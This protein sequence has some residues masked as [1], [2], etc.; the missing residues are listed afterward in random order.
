MSDKEES[1]DAVRRKKRY[2]LR[3][4]KRDEE[5]SDEGEGI[6]E[7][8]G[9][10]QTG[11]YRRITLL[12]KKV[13]NWVKELKD[14]REEERQDREF[15]RALKERVRILE[16]NEKKLREENAKL[17]EELDHYK[18]GLN[19]RLEEV[20]KERETIK[21][22]VN[23]EE[24]KMREVK[25]E[26]KA[27]KE[28]EQES[29]VNL[30]EVIKEQ[31]NERDEDIAKKMVGVLKNKEQLVREIAEKK[32]SVII[33]GMK[34]NKVTYRPRREREELRSV[35]D[36]L[37]NLNDQERQNLEEEVEEIL[38]LGPYKE[39]ISRPVKVVLKSQNATEEV[40]YRTAKL[41]DIEGCKEIYIKKNRNEEER[42]RYK[43]LGAEARMKNEER[44]EEDKKI[45]FWRILGDKVRKWYI[46]EREQVE[47]DK[48]GGTGTGE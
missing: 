32:K 8:F 40:L 7:S 10:P 20:E 36:L 22:M 42:K 35:R 45:F 4:N 16:D 1:G 30:H 2:V 46:R 31:L 27:W 21:E 41:R 24:E 5:Y 33:F 9:S 48:P 37:K 26:V 17:K 3:G 14:E 15:Q 28:R 13:N 34:E 29:K 47:E 38:R 44:S 43:E 12:E 19:E 39:G 18:K 23:K 11:L 25:S 6:F